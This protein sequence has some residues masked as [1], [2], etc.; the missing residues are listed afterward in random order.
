MAQGLV[1]GEK[2]EILQKSKAQNVEKFNKGVT[3]T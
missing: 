3:N 1:R 2:Y